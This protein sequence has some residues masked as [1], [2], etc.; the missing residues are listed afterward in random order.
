MPEDNETD[1]NDELNKKVFKPKP[2]LDL[3]TAPDMDYDDEIKRKKIFKILSQNDVASTLDESILKREKKA[4]TKTTSEE[5]PI[6]RVS[7]LLRSF[8]KFDED[9]ERL[10]GIDKTNFE[11]IDALVDKFSSDEMEQ[12]LKIFLLER[13]KIKSTLTRL[14]KKVNQTSDELEQEEEKIRKI[15]KEIQLRQNGIDDQ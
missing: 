6:R 9:I 7:D 13:D 1:E 5:V 15:K 12:E 10:R 8:S 14:V 3:S 11:S 2:R 4:S